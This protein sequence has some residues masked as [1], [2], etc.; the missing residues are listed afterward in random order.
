MFHSGVI[1]GGGLGVSYQELVEKFCTL[2]VVVVELRRSCD[3]MV[4]LQ[5]AVDFVT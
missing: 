2:Q 4:R 1:L 3:V 5:V